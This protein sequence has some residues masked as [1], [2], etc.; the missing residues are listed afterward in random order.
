MESEAKTISFDHSY[1][2]STVQHEAMKRIFFNENVLEI[3]L[4]YMGYVS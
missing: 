1:F 2:Y 4:H 3:A